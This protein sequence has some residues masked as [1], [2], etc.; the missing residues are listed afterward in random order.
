M[1]LRFCADGA[2]GGEAAH[3]HK[4]AMAD[5]IILATARHYDATIWTQDADFEGLEKVKFRAKAK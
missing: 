1:W 2:H 4:L 5:G 3:E